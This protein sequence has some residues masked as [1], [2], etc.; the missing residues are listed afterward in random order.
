MK[1]FILI[2][3][4]ILLETFYWSVSASAGIFSMDNTS[5]ANQG[6]GEMA[7]EIPAFFNA[8]KLIQKRQEEARRL[9]AEGRK[10]IEKGEKKKD[11]SLIAKGQIKKEIGEKQL[12]VLKEQTRV[13]K[14]ETSGW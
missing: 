2:C 8:D 1:R 3:L 4:L 14:N 7:E 10:L 9:I 11:Q 12:A 6:Q 13:R 5:T